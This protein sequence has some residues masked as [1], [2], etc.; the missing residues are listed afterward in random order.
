MYFVLMHIPQSMP[1]YIA[2]FHLACYLLIAGCLWINILSIV[3][4]LCFGGLVLCL[5]P[6]LRKKQPDEATDVSTA[7]TL[8]KTSIMEDLDREARRRK[9]V[10]QLE[11]N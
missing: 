8:E 6:Y 9:E 4:L 1:K 2:S 3:Y 10:E 11:R 7:S 5:Y